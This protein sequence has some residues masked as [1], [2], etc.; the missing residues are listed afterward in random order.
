MTTISNL[1]ELDSHDVELLDNDALNPH[2]VKLWD[3]EL[4]PHKVDA[5]KDFDVQVCRAS[6]N[7]LYTLVCSRKLCI[8]ELKDLYDEFRMCHPY[9]HPCE[10]QVHFSIIHM[11]GVFDKPWRE[12]LINKY[13]PPPSLSL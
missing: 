3:E 5:I 6:C 9:L 11:K 13:P 7:C 12:F 10:V 1:L 4:D 8:Q 2:D